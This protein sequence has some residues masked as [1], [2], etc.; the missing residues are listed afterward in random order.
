MENVRGYM[1][2]E[3]VTVNGLANNQYWS[4]SLKQ[5]VSAIRQNTWIPTR[6]KILS[7]AL[8]LN[9]NKDEIDL[10]LW[11]ANMQPLTPNN[12][13]DAT[14]LYVLETVDVNFLGESKYTCEYN[15]LFE[16][17]ADVI[18]SIGNAELNKLLVEFQN[19][20]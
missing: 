9:L 12:V 5:C 14:I 3:N 1:E 19:R 13:L 17:A 2:E 6:T 4:S 20:D 11:L 7:L 10:L 8:H 18:R 16:Y 15:Y